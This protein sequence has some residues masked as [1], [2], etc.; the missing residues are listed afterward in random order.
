MTHSVENR[1]LAIVATAVF[2]LVVPLFVLFLT[3][4]TER[5]GR[6][7][8]DHVDVLLA[9]NAQA[10]GKP[11][12]DFDEESV[13]RIA[14][15]VISGG[16]ISKVQIR[17]TAGAL[18]VAL[19]AMP[20]WPKGGLRSKSQPIVYE[21]VEGPKVVGSITVY[22]SRRSFLSSLREAEAAIVAIFLITVLAV[23]G[24]A[25][26][27]NR[28]M[29]VK[30]LLKL[31]AAIEATRRLGSR[32]HVD[33][34][35][36]DEMGRLAQSFN[37][38]QIK[39]EQEERELKLAHRRSNEIYNMTPAMLFSIDDDD[40]ITGVS[41]H[42][43][44][45]TGYSRE[46]VL[47]TRFS[48]RIAADAREK[49]LSRKRERQIGECIW[50]CTTKFICADGRVMDVLIIE[51]SKSVEDEAEALSLSVM[52]DIT[53][54]KQSE[55]RNHRQAIT[56]HLTGLMNRQGFESALDE[57]I[58]EADAAHTQLACLFI[59]L[60]RF[61]WIND[62]LGHQAGDSVLKMFVAML[63]PLLP[64]GSVAARL[65][66]DEFAILLLSGDAERTALDVSRRICAIFDAP[67]LLQG[68]AAR[69]SASIGIALYPAHAGNAAELLQKSDLAMYS[70]KR[71]GKNGARVYDPQLQDSTRQR[72]EIES[73]IEAGLEND[74][75]EAFLQ[76]IVDL[77]DGTVM[78][79][80]SLMRLN[81]PQKGLLPPG[82]IINVAEETGSI[83]DIGNRILEKA[84]DNLVMLTEATGDD[85]T[86]LAVNYSPLQFE[87][88]LP[89]RLAALTARRNI[90]PERIVIEITEAMLLRD[91][92][93]VHTILEEFKQFGC[94]IALDDFGTGYSS[95]SYLNRFP[96]DI[97]KIDQSFIRSLTDGQPEKR[98]KSHL[99]A[100]GITDIAHRMGCSVVAEGIESGAQWEIVRDFGCDYGQGYLFARPQ[101]VED[102]IEQH[103]WQQE[104]STYVA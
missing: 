78:G 92:P 23:I 44:L 58:A 82:D 37:A 101:R 103:Q 43:L 93:L 50:E 11:M 66:G 77:T 94:R 9:A 10:L 100:E 52:T 84:L 29:I 81:H 73:F 97:I 62:N 22:F 68:T 63:E 56:D 46:D 41:D 38:M 96:V 53:A 8:E 76:P 54:L 95:L 39:L 20:E 32:H 31:T 40:R 5:A 90:R 99:L 74:W 69:L 80:E 55:A 4:S 57:K 102:L 48:D 88:G 24:A 72:A 14:T 16:A 12:W 71:G 61:K 35:S 19:P 17:D 6:E 1:F 34:H 85:R 26:V 98:K 65:G 75:F 18:S 33:W 86:Y 25:V 79:Y 28:M 49:Y 21:T 91:N 7:L 51:S 2:V 27:G 13:R 64:Q 42:W 59:D 36:N 47:G 45:A 15:T 70:K 83:V 104:K 67:F 30:P 87:P 3:L 89:M 60:D